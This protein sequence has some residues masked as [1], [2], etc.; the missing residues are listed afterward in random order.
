MLG[1]CVNLEC[2]K[3]ID[4]S[5]HFTRK[6]FSVGKFGLWRVNFASFEFSYRFCPCSVPFWKH[7]SVLFVFWR[8][9]TMALE[10]ESCTS[11]KL[12]ERPI[13]SLIFLTPHICFCKMEIQ[14]PLPLSGLSIHAF[15]PK[16]VRCI[17]RKQ[18]PLY[19]TGTHYPFMSFVGQRLCI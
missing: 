4:G 1:K 8:N 11:Q 15:N 3:K 12:A 13:S 18:F 19:W 6:G 10:M 7:V 9:E 16:W 5:I 17:Q 2:L 14:S